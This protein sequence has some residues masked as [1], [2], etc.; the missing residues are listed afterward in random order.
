[1]RLLSHE[2]AELAL[3]ACKCTQFE[4]GGQGL[5][6]AK[7]EKKEKPDLSRAAASFEWAT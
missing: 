1:M 2:R 7:E 5:Q 3:L 6:K 4:I